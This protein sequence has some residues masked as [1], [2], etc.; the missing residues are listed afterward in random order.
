MDFLDSLHGLKAAELKEECRKRGLA[1]GG[2][3]AVMIQ[4][5]KDFMAENEASWQA[6]AAAAAA[7]ARI[8]LSPLAAAAASPQASPEGE[9]SAEK[10]AS[11]A[12][13][14]EEQEA[15]PEQ[16]PA[17]APEEPAVEQPAAAE[18]EPAAAAEAAAEA[19]TEVAAAMEQD[20]NEAEEAA[21]PKRASPPKAAPAAAAPVAASA[22]VDLDYGEESDGEGA[23]A[24]PAPAAEEEQAER[25]K[26][27]GA[28]RSVPRLQG[29]CRA[30]P[31]VACPRRPRQH[32]PPLPPAPGPHA[33]GLKRKR[34][35]GAAQVGPSAEKALAAA[36]G[37]GS[38][39]RPSKVPRT[40][41]GFAL[42]NAGGGEGGAGGWWVRG[43]DGVPC[44]GQTVHLNSPAAATP[45]NLL[46]LQRRGRRRLRRTCRRRPS[47]RHARCGSTALCGPSQSARWAAAHACPVPSA[48]VA[49][50]P[51]SHAGRTSSHPCLLSLP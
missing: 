8:L 22:D 43:G 14:E 2:T 35:S 23:G 25:A 42:G 46:P 30:H 45:A 44:C 9:A 19:A 15:E 11:E 41:S 32:P 20:R 12:Q 34:A 6:A 5:L 31:C 21:P 39:D 24:A 49:P 4:R 1:V 50:R 36:V 3:K 51:P 33:E 10:P 38:A 29:A 7:A 47:P 40:G 13:Q 48:R 26:P 18:Q 16:E 37:Q 28:G 27:E 17:S